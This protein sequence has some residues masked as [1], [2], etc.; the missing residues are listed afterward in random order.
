MH[1]RCKIHSSKLCLVV[2]YFLKIQKK[3]CLQ[4]FRGLTSNQARLYQAVVT[5]TASTAVA[6]TNR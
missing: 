2:T 4:S 5:E 1:L 6:T 3:T